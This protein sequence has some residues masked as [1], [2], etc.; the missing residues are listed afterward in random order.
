[1]IGS[2]L[3]RIPLRFTGWQF[4]GP[5]PRIEK[6]VCLGL[7]HTSNWD[8]VLLLSL[9]KSI[10]QPISFMIKDDW[11]RGP[12][13]GALVRL[14]AVPI[15]RR[16]ASNVVQQMID[17][18]N[19]RDKFVL[20]VPPEGTRKRAEHWKSGFYYIAVGAK[21]P[22]VPGYLDYRRKRGGMLAPIAMTGNVKRD[23]D[24]IR[25]AY[26][27]CQYEGKVPENFGPIRLKDEDP[28]TAKSRD[29][30]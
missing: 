15:N 17:V 8:G 3:V 1:M 10:G 29:I 21:V 26:S 20:C 9:M 19:E 24:A 4:E 25:A 6:F 23:M 5:P 22:V 13:G 18:F 7:P 14:G 12:M 30:N 2:Q 27:H 11:I 28:Q 16:S